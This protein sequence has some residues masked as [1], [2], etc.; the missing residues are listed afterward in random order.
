MAGANLPLALFGAVLMQLRSGEVRAPLPLSARGR[1]CCQAAV[2]VSQLYNLDRLKIMEFWCTV[3]LS[4]IG[5]KLVP[6]TSA[7]QAGSRTWA[8]SASG[9]S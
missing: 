2:S 4:P 7:A 8:E 1:S 3:P 6:W 9:N 5:I